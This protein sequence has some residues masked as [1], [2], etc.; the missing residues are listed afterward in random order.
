MWGPLWWGRVMFAVGLNQGWWDFGSTVEFTRGMPQSQKLI[1]SLCRVFFFI[2]W[3]IFR[4]GVSLSFRWKLFLSL[5]I[6]S[7]IFLHAIRRKCEFQCFGEGGRNCKMW[8]WESTWG[9]RDSWTSRCMHL[10]IIAFWST[11][12]CLFLSWPLIL[13]PWS[14]AYLDPVLFVVCIHSSGQCSSLGLYIGLG[15][16]PQKT[17]GLDPLRLPDGV[18]QPNVLTQN[19]LNILQMVWAQAYSVGFWAGSRTE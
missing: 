12:C 5:K 6:S 2:R 11:Y 9:T 13:V 14:G 18:T 17:N 8:E 19:D 1:I 4:D 7:N 16:M 10:G 15:L 3:D